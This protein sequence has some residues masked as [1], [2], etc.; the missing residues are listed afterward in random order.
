[1]TITMTASTS[2]K[3]IAVRLSSASES[4]D[5]RSES[6]ESRVEGMTKEPQGSRP[7]RRTGPIRGEAG[8]KARPVGRRFACLGS[9][10]HGRRAKDQRQRVQPVGCNL[11]MQSPPGPPITTADYDLAL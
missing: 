9:I 1:M 10:M 3:A 7:D 11:R 2:P 4:R 6:C 5:S 8:D